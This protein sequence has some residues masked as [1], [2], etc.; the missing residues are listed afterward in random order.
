MFYIYGLGGLLP[1]AQKALLYTVDACGDSICK[2]GEDDLEKTVEE[3]LNSK[4]VI[5]IS[6]FKPE[7]NKE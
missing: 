7:A 5:A 4:E 3:C 1:E 6:S 2:I